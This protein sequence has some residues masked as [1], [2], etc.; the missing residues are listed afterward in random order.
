M[1]LALEIEN[2]VIVTFA[3]SGLTTLSGRF[4]VWWDSFTCGDKCVTL[5]PGACL[6]SS[7]CGQTVP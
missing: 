5:A 6:V 7:P 4:H 3:L 1:E 2:E